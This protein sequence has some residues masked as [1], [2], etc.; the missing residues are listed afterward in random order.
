MGIIFKELYSRVN[1]E[2]TKNK[3]KSRNYKDFRWTAMEQFSFALWLLEKLNKS[4][5]LSDKLR[6]FLKCSKKLENNTLVSEFLL[7]YGW[8][9]RFDLSEVVMYDK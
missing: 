8:D 5:S 1:S 9:I 4:K 6:K 7:S 3:L 2:F